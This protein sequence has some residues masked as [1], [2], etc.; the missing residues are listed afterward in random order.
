M[1]E[2]RDIIF[3]LRHFNV[4]ETLQLSNSNS[5]PILKRCNIDYFVGNNI[6]CYNV[7]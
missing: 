7:G 3:S 1:N 6:H 2:N 4:L 5:L